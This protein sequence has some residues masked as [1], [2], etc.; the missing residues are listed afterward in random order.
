MQYTPKELTDSNLQKVA[1]MLRILAPDY[2]THAVISSTTLTNT[3]PK[4]SEVINMHQVVFELLRR[5]L[6]ARGINTDIINPVKSEK[7]IVKDLNG[8]CSELYNDFLKV[9]PDEIE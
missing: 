4:Y 5:K 8:Y 3:Q 2:Y 7:I 6:S 9:Y 1:H